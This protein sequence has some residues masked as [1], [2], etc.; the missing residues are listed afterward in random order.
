MLV[1]AAQFLVSILFILSF[2]AGPVSEWRIL[3]LGLF[4]FADFIASSCM[5]LGAVVMLAYVIV[6]WG[7]GKFKQEANLGAEGKIRV[8]DWMKPYVCY[9]YPIV[10][11]VVTYCIIDM[12]F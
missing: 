2:G 3:G 12:Y 8:M 6:R 4:D 5:C 7:F 10:L 9:I 11:L 1:V